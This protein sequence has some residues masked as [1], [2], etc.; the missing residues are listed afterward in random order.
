[1]IAAT[2]RIPATISEAIFAHC[3]AVAIAERIVALGDVFQ[4]HAVVNQRLP[5]VCRA[6]VPYRISQDVRTWPR[7]E[8]LNLDANAIYGK[9]VVV[10][11]PCTLTA[12]KQRVAR[13][14]SAPRTFTGNILHNVNYRTF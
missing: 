1:M 10:R 13:T 14:E 7:F 3:P 12:F 2:E 9:V 11:A 8:S 6:H 4:D 5:A